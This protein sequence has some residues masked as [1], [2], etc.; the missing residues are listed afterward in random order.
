VTAWKGVPDD[1]TLPSDYTNDGN[2]FGAYLWK[3]Q[4]V[5]SPD[6]DPALDITGKFTLGR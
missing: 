5:K 1:P 4:V 2:L 3:S 6:A